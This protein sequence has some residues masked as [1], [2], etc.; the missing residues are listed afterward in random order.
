MLKDTQKKISDAFTRMAFDLITDI[1]DSILPKIENPEKR[2]KLLTKQAAA[3]AAAISATLA[4]PGGFAGVLTSLPDLYTIWKIQAKLVADIAAS[5][6]KYAELNK[7]A[8]LWCLFRHSASQVLRDLFVKTSNRI[9]TQKISLLALQN[10]LKQIG[11]QQASKFLSK[12]F[13]K[14]VPLAGALASGAYAAYDT[15]EVGK[16]ALTYFKALAKNQ[17]HPQEIKES[18]E[19]KCDRYQ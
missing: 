4:I 3:K 19:I 1:P 14:I 7:E 17:E 18:K 2:A 16:T 13:V 6:G 15:R 8:M 9:I 10:I 11:V 12:H 5:F